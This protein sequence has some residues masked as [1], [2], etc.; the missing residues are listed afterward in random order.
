[1]LPRRCSAIKKVGVLIDAGKRLSIDKLSNSIRKLLGLGVPIKSIE[2]AVNFL[3]G[4]V[5]FVGSKADTP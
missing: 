5:R 4:R 3:N 2:D 1:M